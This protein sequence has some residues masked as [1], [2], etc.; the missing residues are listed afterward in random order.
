VRTE[1]RRPPRVSGRVLD[2]TRLLTTVFFPATVLIGL[3]VVTHGAITPGGGFQG[4][5]VVATGLHLLYV[6]GQYP[7]LERLRPVSWHDRAEAG[8]LIIFVLVGLLGLVAVGA[9]FA[10]VLPRGQL[11]ELLSAG[12]VPLL[13]VAVGLAVTGG[14]VVLLAGFL[15]QALVIT[16]DEYPSADE[17]G[18]EQ[19]QGAAS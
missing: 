4:G 17:A 3:D 11:T 18:S 9:V 10:N 1:R 16:E 14:V 2:S 13:N 12:T 7:V 8:S 6:G 15:E 19:E 5:V